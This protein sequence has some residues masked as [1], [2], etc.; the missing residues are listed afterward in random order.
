[1]EV[2]FCSS[3]FGHKKGEFCPRLKLEQHF[4]SFFRTDFMYEKNGKLLRGNNGD[5]MIIPRG[6]IV[7]H[8]PTPEMTEGFRNDWM[9]INGDDFIELVKKY[10]IPIGTLFKVG[11]AMLLHTALKK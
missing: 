6:E 2:V 5:M 1:M 3:D 8:D 9:H 11:D 10:E 7:W 4:I